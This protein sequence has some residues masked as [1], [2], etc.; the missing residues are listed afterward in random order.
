[1]DDSPDVI[2][3]DMAPKRTLK[4]KIRRVIR[5]FTSKCADRHS[6]LRT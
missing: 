3:P 5:A 4:E 1:M 2:G 6:P